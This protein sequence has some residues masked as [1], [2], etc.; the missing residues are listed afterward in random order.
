[1][2]RESKALANKILRRQLHICVLEYIG[3]LNLVISFERMARLGTEVNSSSTD[4]DRN[5]ALQKW[6]LSI[7]SVALFLLM[8]DGT[9]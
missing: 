7:A 9:S 8:L 6:C 3:A 5:D 2:G 4:I 1:V